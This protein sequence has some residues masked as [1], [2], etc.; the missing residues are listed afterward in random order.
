[1]LSAME[2]ALGVALGVLGVAL[3]GLAAVLVRGRRRPHQRPVT[4]GPGIG[5]DD[6]PGFLESPPG[7]GPADARTGWTSLTAPPPP[8]PGRPPRG[9]D[10]RLGPPPPPRPPPP[11]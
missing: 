2:I 6:L 3:A 10:D 1:M 8:T 11:F 9:P 4:S 7:T 5:E